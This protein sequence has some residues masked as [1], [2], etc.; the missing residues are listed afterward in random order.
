MENK[1]RVA[2]LAIGFTL[3]GLSSFGTYNAITAR[4]HPEPE[5][6]IP[7]ANLIT[8]RGMTIE[9]MGTEQALMGFGEGLVGLFVLVPPVLAR[10]RDRQTSEQ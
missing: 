2:R 10:R 5:R 7:R 1:E 9:A 8:G 4:M 3:F 6:I